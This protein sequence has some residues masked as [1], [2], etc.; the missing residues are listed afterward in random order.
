[1]A[2]KERFDGIIP[3]AVTPL[4]EDGRLDEAGVEKL[5]EHML[6][7][8]VSGLFI[9]GTS[10][11]A[12]RLPDA[13]WEQNTRAYLRA[14]QGR[15]PVFCGAI[16][17]CAARVVE[18]IKRIEDIGGRIAVC[19]PPF[20]LRSFGQE[21]ILRHVS[22]ILDHTCIELALYNIPETTHALIEPETV[23]KLAEYERVVVMK[24]SSADWQHL[25]RVLFLCE[26]KD[27][28]IF[29]GAEELCATA[30]LYGANGCI[31]GLANYLP[32]LFVSLYEASRAGRIRE[33]YLL[34]KQIYEI[35]KVIFVNGCWMSGMKFLNKAFGLACDGI[36]A[37]L[38][39][40]S[41]AQE[42]QALK[43]LADSGVETALQ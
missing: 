38:V 41:A 6:A 20:Y 36:S 11:E 19:T 43:I 31:P 35:R 13:I 22:Y 16:D 7:G 8:G 30:M 39:R 18:K 37:G 4:L 32:R 33:S 27:I 29:N 5:T 24:D 14:A 17:T 25:Q 12:M 26:D 34:Q 23:A 10:G 28:A 15:V 42:A 21:E 40:L 9:N 1:M 2:S 3:P